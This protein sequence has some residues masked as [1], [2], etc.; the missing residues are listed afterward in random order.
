MTTRL[1][2]VYTKIWQSRVLSQITFA[3]QV[4]NEKQLS[5]YLY[6][7]ISKTIERFKQD[8][9]TLFFPCMPH[10]I[11]IHLENCSAFNYELNPKQCFI[12]DWLFRLYNLWLHVGLHAH[13]ITSQ[14]RTQ[15]R[16]YTSKVSGAYRA[17]NLLLDAIYF[18]TCKKKMYWRKYSDNLHEYT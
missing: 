2:A 15:W 11:S 16:I 14:H 13:L 17:S 10:D 7:V 4:G 9:H 12:I 1:T 5:L 8:Y 6:S 3:E 18:W